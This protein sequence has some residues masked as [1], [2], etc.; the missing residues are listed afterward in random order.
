MPAK[1][2]LFIAALVTGAAA[3]GTVAATN[4]FADGGA[5]PAPVPSTAAPSSAPTRSDP[6]TAPVT[7]AAM[8][9]T[10]FAGIK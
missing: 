5:Q 10:R 3:L 9:R 8:N 2:V 4:A 6:A 7:S 1:R